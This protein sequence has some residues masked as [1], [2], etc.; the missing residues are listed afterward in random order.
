MR[1]DRLGGGY[2]LLLDTEVLVR[3]LSRDSL[4]VLL[5]STFEMNVPEEFKK[6]CEKISGKL[7]W[8]DGLWRYRSDLI[9]RDNCTPAEHK[10]LNELDEL[11]KNP[12]LILTTHLP[13]DSILV[14]D[15][16]RWMHGRTIILDQDRW[17]K[18][19]RFHPVGLPP[20][21]KRLISRSRSLQFEEE[22][23][24]INSIE[25]IDNQGE[26]EKLI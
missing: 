10:A 19:I 13:F 1:E 11:L 8:E 3:Y 26:L 16:S 5:T 24:L 20:P 2:S 22:L 21:C 7:I 6:G 23:S 12:N 4:K 18:R 17:L 14:L 9:I 25:N 15:N